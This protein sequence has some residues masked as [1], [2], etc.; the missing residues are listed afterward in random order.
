MNER[1]RS[2]A[3]G[4][5]LAV[6]QAPG[7]FT[8]L[9]L[10][11]VLGGAA[12]AAVLLIQKVI[13]DGIAGSTGD[14]GLMSLLRT[15]SLLAAAIAGFL[16]LDLIL[17]FV[18]QFVDFEE[19]TFRDR[20][21]AGT[22]RLILDHLR[23]LRGI[24]PFE[25]P[26]FASRLNLAVASIPSIDHF[27]NALNYLMVGLFAVLPVAALTA[28]LAWW[29]P[30]L[31]IAAVAPSMHVQ[32][33]IEDRS[34]SLKQG[35]AETAKRM[36]A[37][38]QML[39]APDYAKETRLLAIGGLLLG[40][41][42]AM[43]DG[44]LHEVLRLRE[45]GRRTVLVW[46]LLSAAGV[47]GAF[48]FVVQQGLEGT[49]SAGD[50]A[51]YIGSIFYLRRGLMHF[52]HCLVQI[53]AQGLRVKAIQDVLDMD[54]GLRDR[55][56]ALRTESADGLA[57]DDVSFRYAGAQEDA[58]RGV[59]FSVPHGRSVALVGA[60]GSGKTTL[61]KLACRLYDPD[62]GTVSWNGRPL[63]E[64]P[65]EQWRARVSALM[66]DHCRFSGERLRQR[67]VRQCRRPDDDMDG[68]RAAARQSGIG[69]RIE[70][71][72]EQWRTPLA[73]ELTGG[74]D[75][76]GGEWQRLAL[77]RAFYRSE[78]A[79]VLLDEPTYGVDPAAEGD[80][81]ERVRSWIAGR[82]A[83]VVSHRLGLTRFVDDIVV[84]DGGRV[85]ER[86]DHAALM[87]AGG[88]YARMFET[89]AR[90]YRDVG[91]DP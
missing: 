26:A 80:I 72:P 69:E 21:L 36:D 51:L 3:Q 43:F 87:D 78:S 38:E 25:T 23:K 13:V 62:T 32:N 65:V 35:Q 4:F 28:T 59:S 33:R 86:G 41:W 9:L 12:P 46:S 75:L 44:A 40:R 88:L 68:V 81:W 55:Q 79:L 6:R 63:P 73:K 54:D 84:M 20:I 89:Q 8:R 22:K 42:Q 52:L 11:N 58:V 56:A 91:D 30:L 2:V 19:T 49:L 24:R 83:L 60:N 66:Q 53:Q 15:P 10:L 48:L 61:V 67:V 37:H 29:V 82:T 14:T 70:R 57:F 77:A 47:G 85:V 76:S 45:R 7:A 34:W 39:T 1:V 71:L 90:P 50:L 27:G 74:Q 31:T 5:A 18:E 17:D 64:L 16:V